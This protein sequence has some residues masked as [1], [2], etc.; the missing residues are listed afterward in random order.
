[1]STN[2]GAEVGSS[3]QTESEINVEQ[4]Q[5]TTTKKSSTGGGEVTMDTKITSLKDLKEKAPKV[6]KAMM[7]GIATNI[8][9]DMQNA[10][11]RIHQL[12]VQARAESGG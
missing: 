10:Q 8:C 9:K 3:A 5:T 4:Q 6:W 7:I 11:D 1:M 2:G 12:N